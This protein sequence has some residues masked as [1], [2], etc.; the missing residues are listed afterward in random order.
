MVDTVI[1][2]GDRGVPALAVIFLVERKKVLY[3][4]G[5]VTM[6]QPGRP[7]PAPFVVTCVCVC[8]PVTDHY[9]MLGK[10]LDPG[11]IWGHFGFCCTV[12]KDGLLQGAPG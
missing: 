8:G 6:P 11:R 4:W 10:E 5:P 12:G 1:M 9:V 2:H 3:L 7:F